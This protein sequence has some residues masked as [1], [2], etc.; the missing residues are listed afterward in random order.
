MLITNTVYTD[1]FNKLNFKTLTESFAPLK[2][3][4]GYIN[5]SHSAIHLLCTKN[6]TIG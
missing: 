1:I 2:N 5:S 4:V 3:Q 6:I